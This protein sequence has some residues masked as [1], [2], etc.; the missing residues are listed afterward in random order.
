MDTKICKDPSRSCSGSER[1]RPAFGIR[2]LWWNVLLGLLTTALI[3]ACA[4]APGSPRA[5]TAGEEPLPTPQPGA[6]TVES[7]RI[8]SAVVADEQPYFATLSPDG[9]QIAW[10]KETGR[11]QE[12]NGS[13]CL[14]S[15]ANASKRCNN[16][17]AG[18]FL[19]YPVQLQWSPD[20][21]RIAFTEN[22]LQLGND[23][24]IWVMNVAEGTYTNLTDDGVTGNWQYQAGS[25][26]AL[27]DY[28]PMWN[29]ADGRIYFWRVLPQG[30]PKYQFGL[31]SIAPEGGEPV[32][33]R[34][35]TT[36][37]PNQIP[38]FDYQALYMDGSSAVSPDGTHI[39]ALLSVFSEMGGTSANLWLIDLKQP[40]AAP[41][42][43]MTYDD[44][45]S[46]IPEW[47]ALPANPMGLSWAADGKSLVITALANDVSS[48]APFLVFYNVAADGSGY[49]PVVDFSGLADLSAYGALAPETG[50]PWRAYSPWTGSLSPKG[51]KVLMINNLGGSIALFTAP[52][53][54]S[55]ALPPISVAA[56][57]SLNGTSVNS[58]RSSDGKVLMYGLL[59]TVKEP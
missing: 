57:Q 28:L 11:G 38:T 12:R 23:P 2:P 58:S 14:F 6:V 40:N 44:F 27:V 53:P 21:K 42:Q 9:T 33:L 41:K 5:A 7:A 47:T 18:K 36:V 48:Q 31:Y 19:G 15:F 3:T 56:Q 10:F 54:P 24:D 26:Q 51:D 49:K 25:P 37:V 8:V 17:P 30:F 52:L 46:A 16:F 39:A 20:S 29:P 32:A 4:S 35:L 43:L 34:D 55:G 45:Q 50:L 1:K 13:I 59:L 22:P